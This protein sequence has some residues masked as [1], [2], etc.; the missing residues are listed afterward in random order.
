MVTRVPERPSLN[1][2]SRGADNVITTLHSSRM[3]WNSFSKYIRNN[4]KSL[5]LGCGLVAAV[6]L[7]RNRFKVQPKPKLPNRHADYFQDDFDDARRLFRDYAKKA[8]PIS[9]DNPWLTALKLLNKAGAELHILPLEGECW[10]G[11]CGDPHAFEGEARLTIDVAVVR[12]Q[13]AP[14]KAGP[15][16]LHMSGVHGV[17]GH[18]G[19]AIQCKFL[20]EIAEGASAFPLHQR[21]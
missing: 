11:E 1:A 12:G 16:M 7:W 21:R 14:E 5:A 15:L 20:D 2:F 19:S 18:S 10:G 3:E 9:T 17:E 8:Y 13:H 6:S 4:L